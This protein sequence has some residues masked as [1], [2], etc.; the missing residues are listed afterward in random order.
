MELNSFKKHLDQMTEG[1]NDRYYIAGGSIAA[2]STSPFL[3][4][5]KQ[6]RTEVMYS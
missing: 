5:M 3:E 2:V 6:K 4:S 1:Q